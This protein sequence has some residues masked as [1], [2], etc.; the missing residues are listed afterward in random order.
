[1]L[2]SSMAWDED[3]VGRLLIEVSNDTSS[4]PPTINLIGTKEY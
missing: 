1:M 2:S 4:S 3:L